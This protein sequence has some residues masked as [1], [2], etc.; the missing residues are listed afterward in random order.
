MG[1][2]AGNRRI[3]PDRPDLRPKLDVLLCVRCVV[4]PVFPYFLSSSHRIVEGRFPI[5]GGVRKQRHRPVWVAIDPEARPY[6]SSQFCTSCSA[7]AR[8]LGF[9]E[10]YFGSS[11]FPSD[12][13]LIRELCGAGCDF[14]HSGVPQTL[15][16]RVSALSPKKDAVGF[17]VSD[18]R[19]AWHAVVP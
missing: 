3:V 16:G 19:D 1:L 13:P 6:S 4:L 5:S 12:T 17:A 9:R 14:S 15:P 2:P 10:G 8:C 7:I 11:C 18:F